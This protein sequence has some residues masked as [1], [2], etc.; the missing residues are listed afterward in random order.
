MDA[1]TRT[2]A[3]VLWD[4]DGTLIASEHLWQRTHHKIATDHGGQWSPKSSADMVGLAWPVA[5]EY[6]LNMIGMTDRPVTYIYD[7]WLAHMPGLLRDEATWMPGAR[8]LLDEVVGLGVPCG[9]VTASFQP[10]VQPL[11]ETLPAGTFQ[12]VVTGDQVK[13]GKPHPEPYLTAA[14]RIGV[15]P[16]DCLVI[17][18]SNA[19]SDAG[20][21]AGAVVLAV[22]SEFPVRPAPR[23]VHRESLD[24]L[25]WAGTKALVASAWQE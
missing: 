10:I 15:D 2:P 5:A 25:D 7:Q 21:A 16:S 3:A 1:M 20:N 4:F 18:D 9:L 23:R 22:P 12:T 14:E 13:H 19:G 8:E 24:G 6:M 17:E 11:L